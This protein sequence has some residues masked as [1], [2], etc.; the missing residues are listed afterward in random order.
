MNYTETNKEVTIAA[1]EFIRR[2]RDVERIREYCLQCPGYGKAWNCPPFDFDARTVSDGFKTV[3][4]M[5]TIIEFDEPT[6]AAC[7][8]PEQSMAVG[9]QAM[10]EVWKTLLPRLYGMEQETPGSRC[11][12]FRCVLCPEGCTRPEGFDIEAMT[13]DL[14]DLHLEWSQDGSLSKHITLV[15]ALFLP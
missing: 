6:R 10:E 13:R 9:K 3:R 1:D 4:L 14:L 12:T 7:K 2:Y 8:S 15:T 5:A 11:F